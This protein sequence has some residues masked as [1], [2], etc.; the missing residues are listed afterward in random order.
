MGVRGEGRWWNSACERV[1]MRGCVCV[2][3]CVP[4]E[5]WKRKLLSA[6]EL[7]ERAAVSPQMNH[8][9]PKQLIYNDA[10]CVRHQS[11]ASCSLGQDLTLSTCMLCA[12]VRSGPASCPK[13]RRLH[14]PLCH[15]ALPCRQVGVC[16][17]IPLTPPAP[18]DLLQHGDAGLCC[19]PVRAS[20]STHPRVRLLLVP[21]NP[22]LRT[23]QVEHEE[24]HP[25][26][27]RHDG[28]LM[29]LELSC[30]VVLLVHPLL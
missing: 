17:R 10:S 4:E 11:G 29:H 26:A 30:V 20:A 27:L 3:V 18:P 12:F 6:K 7:P 2:R 23:T 8:L 21:A 13:G 9:D 15:L 22:R 19:A 5:T 16:L 25:G 24:R 1:R 28:C 14:G